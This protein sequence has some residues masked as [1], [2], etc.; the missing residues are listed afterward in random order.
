[1]MYSGSKI[2]RNQQDVSMG[3]QCRRHDADNALSPWPAAVESMHHWSGRLRNCSAG[4]QGGRDTVQADGS[5]R[6]GSR[7]PTA[8]CTVRCQSQLKM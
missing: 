4:V 3:D 7:Q 2:F 5:V 1:M 8:V 6:A